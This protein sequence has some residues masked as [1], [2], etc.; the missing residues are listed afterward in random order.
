MRQHLTVRLVKPQHRL[1]REVAESPFLE[2]IK[3][4]L[5]TALRNLLWLVCLY[6]RGLGQDELKDLCCYPSCDSRKRKK[7]QKKSEL[8]TS[9]D[10]QKGKNKE[11]K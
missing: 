3:T 1:P 2:R 8:K 10:F 4:C 5:S 11:K 9:L 7:K 6:G